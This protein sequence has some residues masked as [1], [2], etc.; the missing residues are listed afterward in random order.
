MALRFALYLL[1]LLV[2]VPWLVR[3]ARTRK[4]YEYPVVSFCFLGLFVC[5]AVGS[6]LVA[7]PTWYD[8][9]DVWTVEYVLLLIAQA[10]LFYAVTGVYFLFVKGRPRPAPA[11]PR[12]ASELLFLHVLLALV[13]IILLVYV[14]DVG[15]PPLIEIIRGNLDETNVIGYRTETTVGLDRFYLYNLAFGP[16]PVVLC[17]Q[18]FVLKLTRR[19]PAA[20]A[21]ALMALA[22]FFASLPGGKGSIID[23]LTALGIA[24]M[25]VLWGYLGGT[26]RPL[27]MSRLVL[28]ALLG[29][30]PVLLMYRLYMGPEA[31]ASS[32]LS[33]LTYRIIGVYSETTAGS[34]IYTQ[35][36]GFLHGASFPTIRGLLKHT[37]VGLSD[38]M[39]FFLFGGP[40]GAPVP[41][42]GEGF[43]NFGWPGFLVLTLIAYAIVIGLQEAFRRMEMD[44]F[45]LSLLIFY[46]LAATKMAQTS[47]FANLVS[48]TYTAAIVCLI[49]LRVVLSIVSLPT[50]AAL[51]RPEAP[52]G[53]AP[54]RLR[55]GAPTRLR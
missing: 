52:V 22:F 2:Y 51:R 27:R 34:V 5:N 10:V 35:V 43:V 26:P 44:V 12:L 29:V 1:T 45:R 36:V 33:S 9:P 6:L 16:L 49:A 48:L 46:V 54:T 17:V 19:L 20:Y 32:I 8:R 7:F 30:T 3:A 21:Y 23:I 28:P 15:M 42:A 31:A 14:N 4:F 13:C 50:R 37:Q 39:H 55:E 40:G 38:E 25:L 24:Y 11:P 18:A 47:L 53:P 41:V